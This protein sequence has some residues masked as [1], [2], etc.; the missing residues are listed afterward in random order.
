MASTSAFA[1]IQRHRSN[2]AAR[3]Q[4]WRNIAGV[5]RPRQ[6]R[7]Y[8]P[9]LPREERR[10][11]L[12][13]AA[14]TVLDGC[15]LHELSMEAVAEAAGVGKPVLYTVFRT[16]AELVSA[17]LRREHQ[18]GLEQVLAGMPDDLAAPGPTGAYAVDGVGV[19]GV[20]AG[21]PHAVAADPDGARQRAARI[22]RR[23]CAGRGRRSWR[24]PSN[25]PRP[26]S[27]WSRGWR[28]L[29]PRLLGHTM[30][31]FAEMLG[32]LALNDPDVY[33]RERLRVLCRCG[34][35]GSRRDAASCRRPALVRAPVRRRPG[36]WSPS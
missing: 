34:H 11:Q 12:L 33:P 3:I 4:R 9:R 21:Q 25:W 17:L 15:Q 8:A 30:L 28:G 13:D 36:P 26:A 1:S 6:R 7:K 16:R 23:H 32:R 27:R 31:S 35:G 2:C 24:R 20:G 22:P 19:P 29:D 14:M 18:R 5:T 10:E